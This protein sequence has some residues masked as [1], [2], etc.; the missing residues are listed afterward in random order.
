[1]LE[2]NSQQV[3][4]VFSRI[5]SRQSP[6]HHSYCTEIRQKSAAT[7]F[8]WHD[9]IMCRGMRACSL[10]LSLVPHSVTRCNSATRCRSCVTKVLNPTVTASRLAE[11]R[12]SCL[13]PGATG[14]RR[15]IIDA[16][17][18]VTCSLRLVGCCGAGHPL[19]FSLLLAAQRPVQRSDGLVMQA[20]NRAN[21]ARVSRPRLR[22]VG[23]QRPD[24][25]LS[26]GAFGTFESSLVCDRAF[27]R[28]P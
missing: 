8:A 23:E 16:S 15:I 3:T 9:R 12:T 14:M 25:L 24:T 17:A 28:G 27:A 18:A 11:P 2:S 20:R 26:Y 21:L 6:L 1:M 4:R 13:A 22:R 10:Q 19:E 5:C 7:M